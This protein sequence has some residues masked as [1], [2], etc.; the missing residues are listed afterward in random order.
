MNAFSQELLTRSP[1][2][3]TAEKVQEFFD[4]T[5]SMKC[6]RCVNGER[7]KVPGLLGLTYNEVVRDLREIEIN[8]DERLVVSR[9]T[10]TPHVLTK[11]KP[12]KTEVVVKR[13]PALGQDADDLGLEW[14]RREWVINP[15]GEVKFT[16]DKEGYDQS[17]VRGPLGPDSLIYSQVLREIREQQDEVINQ[18]H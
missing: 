15:S 6:I 11:P 5:K 2:E 14:Q 10:T 12:P 4:V 18:N 17:I 1:L 13:L 8:S 7:S 16:G 3:Q 9:I